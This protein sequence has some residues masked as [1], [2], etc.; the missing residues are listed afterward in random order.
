MRDVAARAEVALG[1]LYRHYASKDQLL[2]AALADQAA[3]LRER[4][5]QRP[6][7][8]D[9]PGDRVADVL[10]R[11]TRALERATRASPRRWSPRCRR[12]DA[13]PRPRSTRST[14][15]LRA[16]I[17]DARSTAHDGPPTSTASSACSARLVRRAHVWSGGLIDADGDGATTSRSAAARSC[18]AEDRPTT[19]VG[20]T[21]AR[22]GSPRSRDSS[23]RP[24]RR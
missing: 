7:H 21:A 14:T 13:G 3:T 8:G 20:S 23:S 19:S 15:T 11:A 6:P 16:I 24:G 10:R 12:R 4:L 1:T 18:S 22:R 17:A 9:T 5:V 2:L